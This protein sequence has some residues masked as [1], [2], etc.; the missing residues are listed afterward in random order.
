MDIIELK[1]IYRQTD[2]TFIDML[3]AVRDNSVN[4][5]DLELLNTRFDPNFVPEDHEKYI[6]LMTTNASARAVNEKRLEK[7][8]APEKNFLSGQTGDIARNLYPNDEQITL[9][10]GAQIMFILNDPER[11]WV[12]GTIGTIVDIKRDTVF[13]EKTDNTVV[14]VHAHTWEISRYLFEDGKFEREIMGTFTQ[15][16][17]KLAWAITIHKSQGKTF[18]KVIIDLGRGSFA[19]GQTYVALSRCTSLEGLVLKKRMCKSSIIMDERVKLFG[20]T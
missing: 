2:C 8:D 1:E 14:K 7:L 11:R 6:Y 4:H 19:H 18:E 3:N 15:I 5:K 10:V 16:P 20:N 17:L 12:N 13:V 9:K